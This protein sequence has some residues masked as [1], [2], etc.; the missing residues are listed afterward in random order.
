MYYILYYYYIIYLIYIKQQR[1]KYSPLQGVRAISEPN[2]R[3][4]IWL[5]G[6]LWKIYE[7]VA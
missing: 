7:N 4:L 6:H 2:V 3:V 5:T 1:C